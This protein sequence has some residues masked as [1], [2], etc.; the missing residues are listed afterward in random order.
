MKVRELLAKIFLTDN[1]YR[2][3]MRQN[4]LIFYA[5]VEGDL[6]TIQD[7]F[8]Q[9]CKLFHYFTA[10]DKCISPINSPKGMAEQILR[11]QHTHSI[12]ILDIIH[13]PVFRIKHSSLETGFCLRL[14]V[15]PNRLF[16]IEPVS[17][18]RRQRLA[19]S[20]GPN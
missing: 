20:V 5:F 1:E 19:L 14:P 16:R 17:V 15:E 13:R 6:T 12:T 10:V 2:F 4:I 8:H 9:C 7:C 18:V 11:C 3:S